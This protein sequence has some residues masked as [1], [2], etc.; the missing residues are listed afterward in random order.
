MIHLNVIY[1]KWKV[2]NQHNIS[3]LKKEEGGTLHKK[4]DAARPLFLF[5]IK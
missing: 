5:I 2:F 4:N 1:I 3:N